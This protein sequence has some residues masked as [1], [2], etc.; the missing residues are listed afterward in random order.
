[1]C[2]K[3]TKNVTIEKNTELEKYSLE[4]PILYDNKVVFST[5]TGF[6]VC[7]NLKILH[8]FEFNDTYICGEPVIHYVD[9]TPFL[10]SFQ[11]DVLEN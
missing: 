8:K 2:N 5:I 4:F 3:Y 11:I 10:L 7:E 1:M 9:K 6:I